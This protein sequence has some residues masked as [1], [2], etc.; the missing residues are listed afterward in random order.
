MIKFKP[1][2][3]QY[4]IHPYFYKIGIYDYVFI[5]SAR[6]WIKSTKTK[7]ELKGYE[8]KGR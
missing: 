2:D 5:W 1:D 3:A 8:I 7:D 6:D 4:Y